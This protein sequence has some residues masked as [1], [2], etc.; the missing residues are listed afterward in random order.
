MNELNLSI[1]KT[2]S[3]RITVHKTVTEHAEHHG[4]RLHKLIENRPPIVCL[5]R[6]S[7]LYYTSRIIGRLKVVQESTF[8]RI[9]NVQ[10]RLGNQP[11]PAS[12]SFLY[13]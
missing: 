10:G 3:V 5:R 8:S 1:V 6:V 9:E 13:V 4:L 12:W 7:V 2:F 11:V